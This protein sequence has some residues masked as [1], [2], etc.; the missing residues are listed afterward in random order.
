M[1]PPSQP[2]AGFHITIRT[3]TRPGVSGLSEKPNVFLRSC[4]SVVLRSTSILGHVAASFY[5]A[6]PI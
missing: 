6:G 4:R 5:P 1:C 2:V 3:V